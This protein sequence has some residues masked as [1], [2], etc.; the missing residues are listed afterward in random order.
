M[1]KIKFAAVSRNYFNMPIWVAQHCKLFED[2]GIDVDIELYEPIDEVTE[3][4]KDG[5]AQLAYGVTEHVI[6]NRENGGSLL[7]I[8]GNVNKLAFSL[9]ANN[10]I[11]KP[12]DL[13]NKIIG[14]SSL[15]AGS[16]SLIMQTLEIHGLY[17]PKDYS[18][19]EVGPI[20]ARWDKLQN[21]EIDAGLQGAPLN[22][23][24]RD[25]GYTTLI[26][27]RDHF[28]DFQFTSL[29]ADEIWVHQ[30]PQTVRSFLRAFIRAHQL[31]FENKNLMVD[32]A[33]K[34]T[35]IAKKYAIAAW[36]EYTT[37]KIFPIDGYA[38]IK[39]IQTLIDVSA[40]IREI[41]NRKGASA[42]NYIDHQFLNK[43]AN[44]LK[45]R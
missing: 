45:S 35:G 3:R 18:I 19:T 43:A 38:N 37:Q 16:S 44:E 41:K 24:A 25:Q 30:N 11:K 27:P 34:E 12:E 13:R 32:I 8:G 1:T 22:Y 29:N 31:F 2:E 21:G 10:L 5:R 14:V 36:E 17:Y 33:M 28:P 7:I 20:L 40:L 9:M 39:G 42:D 15:D 23:I 6:L 4:L 26:E